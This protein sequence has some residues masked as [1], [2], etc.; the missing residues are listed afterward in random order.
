MCDNFKCLSSQ[1]GMDAGLF[2]PC[3]FTFLVISMSIF[4][5]FK[6]YFYTSFSE[7]IDS[8]NISTFMQVCVSRIVPDH[9]HV[10]I[11]EDMCLVGT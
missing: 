10:T 6:Y 8:V 1:V 5:I 11:E 9:V 2:H 7:S 3:F 4:N